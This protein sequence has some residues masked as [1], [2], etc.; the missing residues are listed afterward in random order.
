M[1]RAVLVPACVNF[2]L[3]FAVETVRPGTNPPQRAFQLVACGY[4]MLLATAASPR[5]FPVRHALTRWRGSRAVG[6]KLLWQGLDASIFLAH[7]VPVLMARMEGQLGDNGEDANLVPSDAEYHLALRG[8]VQDFYPL[9]SADKLFLHGC[10]A[11]FRVMGN[12]EPRAEVLEGTQ[13]AT[14]YSQA[15]MR[16]DNPDDDPQLVSDQKRYARDYFINQAVIAATKIGLEHESGRRGTWKFFSD[17]VI[18]L[19]EH[20]D[21]SRTRA[22]RAR[23]LRGWMAGNVAYR[24]YV[25]MYDAPLAAEIGTAA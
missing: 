7:A 18:D 9:P 13:P 6:A 4:D 16:G 3:D 24:N 1:R 8:R 21:D 11:E 2:D 5:A 17:K 19:T 10:L 14:P 15:L 22:F 25:L 20:G 23:L 12:R